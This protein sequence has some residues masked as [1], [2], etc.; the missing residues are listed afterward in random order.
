V[1]I[2]GEI[3]NAASDSPISQGDEIR[4]VDVSGLRLKVEK[5]EQGN[6]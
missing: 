3:W 1:K 5:G 6:E 4:V 2:Q